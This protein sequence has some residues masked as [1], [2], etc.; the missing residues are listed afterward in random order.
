MD[1]AIHTTVKTPHPE[2]SDTDSRCPAEL[3]YSEFA[4]LPLAC[5]A[6]L[7]CCVCSKK[8]VINL[9]GLTVVCRRLRSPSSSTSRY[10]SGCEAGIN[11]IT[12]RGHDRGLSH[13]HAQCASAFSRVDCSQNSAQA[14]PS[15]PTSDA[16]FE[17]GPPKDGH[18]RD[19][20]GW[21][22]PSCREG[23]KMK[24]NRTRAEAAQHTLALDSTSLPAHK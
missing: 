21:A 10:G 6:L 8:Y 22:S 14:P 2:V 4:V 9:S 18:A 24:E 13:S 12:I 15:K 16:E 3:C 19:T 11:L 20:A 1:S 5:G 17:G 23:T 7:Y